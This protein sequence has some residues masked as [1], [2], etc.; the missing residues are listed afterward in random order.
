MSQD[1]FKDTYNELMRMIPRKYMQNYG[2][3][4]RKKHGLDI[5]VKRACENLP[6]VD[7]V[8]CDS[9][10]IDEEATAFKNGGDFMLINVFN[11]D[12]PQSTDNHATEKGI[13]LESDAY[14]LNYY[15]EGVPKS[16]NSFKEACELTVEHHIVP[17]MA[18]CLGNHDMR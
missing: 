2:E 16:G 7:F 8:F 17:F 1:E 18:N 5:F 13:N 11:P 9:I 3:L 12:M 6:D 10:R 15:V 14:L 4:E